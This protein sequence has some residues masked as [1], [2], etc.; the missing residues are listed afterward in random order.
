MSRLLKVKRSSDIGLGQTSS[1]SGKP[2][3]KERGICV[4]G[5]SSTDLYSL[6]HFL[7]NT[8]R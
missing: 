5:G 7:F 1:P 2:K 6:K 3:G 4:L 8:R